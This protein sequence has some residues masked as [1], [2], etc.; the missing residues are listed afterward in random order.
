MTRICRLHPIWKERGGGPSNILIYTYKR[1]VGPA[2]FAGRPSCAGLL[3]ALL[4]VFQASL[5]TNPSLNAHDL[6]PNFSSY[7][8][9]SSMYSDY[10]NSDEEVEFYDEDEEMMDAE[11]V[12]YYSEEDVDMDAFNDDFKITPKGKKKSYEVDYKSLGQAA[13]EGLMKADV[14]HISSIFGVDVRT[15]SF[16]EHQ[17]VLTQ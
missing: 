5:D 2:S 14:E 16:L 15:V 6:L 10:E 9:S 12:L 13:M 8:I 7:Y 11:G 17:Q 3:A 1:E 4:M